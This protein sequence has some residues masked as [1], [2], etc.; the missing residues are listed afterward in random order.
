MQDFTN[1]PTSQENSCF[2]MIG[3]WSHSHMSIWGLDRKIEFGLPDLEGRTHIFKIHAKM[4][5]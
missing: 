5:G 1:A 3:S 2:K 4:P